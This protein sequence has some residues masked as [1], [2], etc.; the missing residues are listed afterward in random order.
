MR[1]ETVAAQLSGVDLPVTVVRGAED[2]AAPSRHAELI[3]ERVPRARHVTVPGAG[4]MLS[5]EAPETLVDAIVAASAGPG[6]P[7]G[8]GLARGVSR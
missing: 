1:R 7:A 4:H 6:Q 2:H 5:F 8:S 3:V